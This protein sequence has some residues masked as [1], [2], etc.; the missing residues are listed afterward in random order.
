MEEY[1][2]NDY[3]LDD[4]DFLTRGKKLNGLTL[5]GYKLDADKPTKLTPLLK[6]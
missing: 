5:K 4:E 2:M 3:K 6:D 1:K